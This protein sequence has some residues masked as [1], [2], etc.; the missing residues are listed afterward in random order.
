MNYPLAFEVACPL[1]IFA[2]PDSGGPPNSYP[3]PT[4]SACK[5]LFE[6]ISFLKDGS[7][8]ICPTRVEVCKRKGQEG[9]TIRFQKYATNY[10]GPLRKDSVIAKHANMQLFATALSDVC[11][12]LHAEVMGRGANGGVNPR[13]QL[14]EI[15]MRRLERGQCHHTPA[16]GWREFTCSYWG[17]F[18]S[19]YVV[20]TDLDLV[21]PS[22][23]ATPWDRN[24]GGGYAHRFAQDVRV[25]KGVLTFAK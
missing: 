24:V 16:L 23:L 5:G 7:A 9:G 13:H 18:R 17:P 12:R 1:A 21:I 8:W 11:Y 22:M 3:L 14:Q 10:G 19:E 15:F 4:W 2:R 6:A 20:D 25:S